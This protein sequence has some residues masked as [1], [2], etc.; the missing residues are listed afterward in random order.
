[1][2]DD[3]VIRLLEEIRDLQRQ[4]LEHHRQALAN[5]STAI[6]MQRRSLT[7]LLPIFLLLV[8]LFAYGPWLWRWAIH[9]LSR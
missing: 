5:Q 3:Q 9:L 7:R 8:F 6:R 1:M 4:T 2:A